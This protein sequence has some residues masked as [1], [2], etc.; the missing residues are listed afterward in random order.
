M[1]LLALAAVEVY[2]V[3]LLGLTLASFGGGLF[4]ATQAT[5]VM[6]AVP[7]EQHGLA[8]PQAFATTYEYNGHRSA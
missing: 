6:Q 3:V 7:L 1:Q 5:L 4:G 8:R 2:F